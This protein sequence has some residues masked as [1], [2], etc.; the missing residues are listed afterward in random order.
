MRLFHISESK[1]K[2]FLDT[3]HQITLSENSDNVFTDTATYVVILIAIFSSYYGTRYVDASEK[4]LGIISAVAVES[5]LKSI[6]LVVLGLFVTYGV[7]NGFERDPYEQAQKFEDLPAKNTFNGLEGSINF[8]ITSSP[9]YVC[10]FF[11]AKTISH[12]TIVEQKGK[13][14]ENSHLVIP[15]L[16]FDF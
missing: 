6:L 2:R 1:L 4:R 5:F 13:T 16:P 8:A 9:F 10:H 14:L 12:T 7:F 11:I 3:F 15:T